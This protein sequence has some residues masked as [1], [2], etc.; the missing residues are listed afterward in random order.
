MDAIFHKI[1]INYALTDRDMKY[2][3]FTLTALLY[4]ISKML[5]LF[6]FFFAIGETAAFLLDM[7]LLILLRCNHGGLHTKHYFSCFLLSFSVLLFSICL[8]PALLTPSKPTI[9]MVLTLCMIVNYLTGPIR[10]KQCQVKDVDIFKRNQI[11]TFVI[12][13]FFLV[14]AYLLPSSRLMLSGFW[15]IVAQSV[16][17][18]IAK[19]SQNHKQKEAIT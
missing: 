15:V 1:Q 12:V 14:A 13:F 3:K 16:Q 17:L 7:T 8:M 18:I 2:L 6:L 5:I 11:H 9:L 10:S 4:D 19:L